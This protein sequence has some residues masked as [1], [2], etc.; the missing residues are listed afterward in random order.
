MSVVLPDRHRHRGELEQRGVLCISE[1]EANRAD[2]RPLRVGIL[3]IMPKGEAYEPYLLFPLSRTIIQI[4]PVWIRLHSHSYKSTDL[5]HLTSYY[6]YFENA[7]AKTP[8]DGLVVT[9]APVEEMEY[10]Q[11]SYWDEITTILTFARQ[12]I[13][14][15]FG[16]C[17]G[18]MALAKMVGIEKE[19]FRQ[20][21]FGVF[22]TR[23]LD[24]SH[25]I[26]GELDDMFWCVQSRHSGISDKVL[27]GEHERGRINLL[28]HSDN[29]G[30]TIFESSDRRFLM[31][32][33]HPEYEAQ[34]LVE[35]YRRDAALGRSD[36]PLP[37]N[38]DVNKPINRWRSHGLEFFAQW[39]R[40]IYEPTSHEG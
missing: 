22:E 14:S 15:T 17:W 2:I 35:E 37:A 18:G 28:A 1:D 6:D 16:I 34:R 40:Y 4:E 12:N 13:T 33:G 24:R 27:E 5:D 20:K 10:E 29:G 31:H 36:V 7:I 25:P 19:M 32:L 26:T 9:G 39:I 21:L 38:L 3:N 11:V 23:N 30:Y 8:L